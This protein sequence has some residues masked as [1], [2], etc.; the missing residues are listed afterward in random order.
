MDGSLPCFLSPNS[1][2][3]VRKLLGRAY[4]REYRL[5]DAI[6]VFVA[7]IRDYPEDADAWA[8]LGNLYRLAGN[9]RMAEWLYW[10]ALELS[11]GH[12]VA[13]EQLRQVRKAAQ[14]VYPEAMTGFTSEDVLGAEQVAALAAC[15][16][17]SGDLHLRQAVREA[18]DQFTQLPERMPAELQQLMPALIE[19]KIR[20]ARAEGM[21]EFADALQ[22]LWIS[23]MRQSNGAWD[24]TTSGEPPAE[25]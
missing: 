3:K 15:L 13:G 21:N 17:A 25:D 9:L 4:L 7:L 23:L 12:P 2:R 24:E 11:P 5:A 8:V 19:Q 10:R 22:S 1:F 16:E 20:Q 18:A 14:Q 6:N